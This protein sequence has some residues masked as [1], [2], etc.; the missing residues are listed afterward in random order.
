[1]SSIPQ[2]D[3]TRFGSK[4]K[5]RRR[6]DM[7]SLIT[8]TIIIVI[9]IIIITCTIPLFKPQV[10]S[11]GSLP[12]GRAVMENNVFVIM[13]KKAVTMIADNKNVCML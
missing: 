11:D 8:T 3:N 6:G 13:Q 4:C 9:I 7:S 1:M 12:R 2:A 5:V 10:T